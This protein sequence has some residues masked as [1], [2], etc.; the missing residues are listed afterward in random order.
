MNLLQLYIVMFKFLSDFFSQFQ[1]FDFFNAI[2]NDDFDIFYVN[3]FPVSD[4][5]LTQYS[6]ENTKYKLGVNF[7]E[8]DRVEILKGN[9]LV[10]RHDSEIGIEIDNIFHGHLQKQISGKIELL[11][12]FARPEDNQ[13]QIQQENLSFQKLE[14]M[15]KL[16][17]DAISKCGKDAVISHSLFI[18]NSQN[19][20]VIRV[21]NLQFS[22]VFLQDQM[23]LQVFDYFDEKRDR[24]LK[25]QQKF[26]HIYMP[27]FD[28]LLGVLSVAEKA[29]GPVK[30]L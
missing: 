27:V 30:D 15:T 26:F 14:L 4:P 1:D 20:F 3:R 23:N 18:D 2:K 21:L 28:N 17:K 12:S 24:E 25:L 29:R 11:K 8:S 7:Y 6:F 5:R 13:I 10:S 9:K 19:S 22:L 16:L